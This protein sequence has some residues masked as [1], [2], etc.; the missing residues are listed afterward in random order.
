MGRTDRGTDD[1]RTPDRDDDS[2]PLKDVDRAVALSERQHPVVRA[3]VDERE[4][5]MRATYADAVLNR[6]D[7][8]G[9]IDAVTR[10]F[11]D[12]DERICLELTDDQ[13]ALYRDAR[14]AHKIG[15]P[16]L[17]FRYGE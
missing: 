10:I 16:M 12:Y 8:Q 9:G 3:L 2:E 11:A 15:A 5:A 1:R 4:A 13:Q 7:V 17:I 6:N 14:R